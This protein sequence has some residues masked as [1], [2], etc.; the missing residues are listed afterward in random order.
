[1]VTQTTIHDGVDPIVAS[2]IGLTTLSARYSTETS[3]A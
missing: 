1:M 3:D 2:I